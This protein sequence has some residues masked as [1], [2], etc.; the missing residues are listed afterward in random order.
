MEFSETTHKSKICDAKPLESIHLGNVAL[1]QERSH[2]LGEK[3]QLL[4]AAGKRF[5]LLLKPKCERPILLAQAV[6]CLQSLLNSIMH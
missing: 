5:N 2:L 3:Q 6:K 4:Y 1:Q